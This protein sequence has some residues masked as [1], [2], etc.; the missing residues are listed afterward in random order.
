MYRCCDYIVFISNKKVI[1]IT[2]LSRKEHTVAQIRELA[3][4]K[5]VLPQVIVRG[6]CV[7]VCEGVHCV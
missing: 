5:D 1:G 7:R 3:C 2:T 6:V 4:I